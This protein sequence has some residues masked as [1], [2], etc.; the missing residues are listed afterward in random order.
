MCPK[1]WAGLMGLSK[2]KTSWYLC[3]LHFECMQ[4]GRCCSGPNEGYIWVTKT[5]AGLIA[6]FLKIT[7][8]QLTRKYLHRVGLRKTIIEEPSSK[9]CIFLQKIGGKK[10]CLIYPVRPSQCRNWPFWPTNLTSPNA[11]NTAAL[12]CPGINRG[13]L[14][15]FEEIKK[16]KS[17]K[18]WWQDAAG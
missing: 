1:P 11:W 3:G 7:I 17:R 8:G 6:D 10:G 16:T 9:D 15:P 14:Y 13:R 5:E 18:R 12:Q 4:C 2:K